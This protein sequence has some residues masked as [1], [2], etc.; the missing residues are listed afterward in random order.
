MPFLLVKVFFPLIL[1]QIRQ[2]P[3]KFIRNR[4][5]AV[6]S[7]RIATQDSPTSQIEAFQRTMLL[8]GLNGVG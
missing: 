6:A 4:V 7:P 2:V 1:L 3:V 8:D 5:V